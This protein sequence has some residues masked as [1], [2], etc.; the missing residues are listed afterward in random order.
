M[1]QELSIR[2]SNVAVTSSYKFKMCGN[3][4]RE[5]YYERISVKVRM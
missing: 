2:I 5:E 1:R 3:H 4:R